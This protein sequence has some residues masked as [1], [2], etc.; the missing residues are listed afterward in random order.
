MIF[1]YQDIISFM[2]C[3]EEKFNICVSIYVLSL[4]LF[5]NYYFPLRFI[6]YVCRCVDVCM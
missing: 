3:V 6:N 2:C 1:F 5:L 4:N